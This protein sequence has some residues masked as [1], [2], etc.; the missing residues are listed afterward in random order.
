MA[1]GGSVLLAALVVDSV[2]NGMFLPL[3]LLFFTRITDVP[4]SLIGL[5]VSL[6][7]VLTLPVPLLAG[8]LADR[9]GPLP[10]VVGA[11][12]AQGL[13]FLWYGQVSGPV[14]IFLAS[15]LI[16]VG[17]RF[18]W[19]CIFTAVAD[20]ADAAES[21][22]SKDSWFGLA[23]MT[24]T[25]GL[26]VGGLITAVAVTSDGYRA[27]AYGSAA[28]LLL[29]G[30]AIAF[31][32]RAPRRP[33]EPGEEVGYRTMLRDRPFLSFAGLNTVFAGTSMMLA[34]G[35]PVFVADGL[36]GPSWLAPV[37]LVGNTVLLTLLTAP[38]VRRL[39]PYRRTRVLI[40]AAALWA[41]WCFVF[42]ALGSGQL[43]WVIPVL[44]AG[45]ALFT[46]AELAHAPIA[47]AL[48]TALSPPAARGRYLASF[49]YSF[50]VAGLIAPAFF[51][52]LFEVRHWLPWLVLG[53]LNMLAALAVHRLERI[54]PAL[55][56]RLS[57]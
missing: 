36:G 13:G 50:T 49:Q 24:R 39:A 1:R 12:L 30:V 46:A 37:V 7:G 38:V 27:V 34:L 29:A 4:L 51:T 55:A 14:G 41:A 16:A 5:L 53:L 3:S 21:S 18:F 31:G 42:A 47:M 17:V 25:A 8:R 11:Q 6:A 20:F 32:V 57:A 9:V 23:T 56:L 19:S 40:G 54:V 10:L 35:L 22:R 48:A 43:A 44:L 26:A 2:G 28:C 52:T 15:G 45:T 33:P